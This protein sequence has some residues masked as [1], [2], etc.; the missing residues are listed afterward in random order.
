MV[1]FDPG[2]CA[3]KGD[4]KSWKKLRSLRCQRSPELGGRSLILQEPHV[5]PGGKE[6]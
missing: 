6:P 4:Y 3:M 1:F 5:Q 2:L